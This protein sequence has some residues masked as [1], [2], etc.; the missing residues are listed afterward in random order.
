MMRAFGKGICLSR[1]QAWSPRLPWKALRADPYRKV[2]IL[3][4]GRCDLGQALFRGGIDG[5]KVFAGSRCNKLAIDKKIMLRGNLQIFVVL[6]RRSKFPCGAEVQPAFL[7]RDHGAAVFR[8]GVART[9]FVSTCGFFR[10]M[11]ER[12]FPERILGII[13]DG[14]SDWKV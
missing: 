9:G 8:S 3:F 13:F 1:A 10:A 11:A 7:Q 14:K 2:H 4:A 6:G 12:F 5:W